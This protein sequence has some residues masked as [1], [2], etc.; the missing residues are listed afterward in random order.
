M[1]FSPTWYF[2]K[3]E[4]VS[5]EFLR[6]NGVSALIL[7]VDNTLTTHDNP[8]P[9]AGVAV[10]LEKMRAAGITMMILSNNKVERVRP[11]AKA[12]G[13]PCIPNG[14]KPLPDGIR[15]TL[16][17]MG[18]QRE[19]TIVVGDQVFTDV[20]AGKWSGLRTLLVEPIQPEAT[21]FFRF[22]RA[23]EKICLAGYHRKRRKNNR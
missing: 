3:I 13:L 11:F 10:W 7:D 22:K 19:K 1:P 14:K 8:M 23:M 17:A 9:K 15:R 6:E 18:T 5:P 4:D 16:H 2:E 12:L 21:A 20:L